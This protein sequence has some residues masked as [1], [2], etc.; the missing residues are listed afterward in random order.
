[1][2]DFGK[3]KGADIDDILEEDPGYLV[4]CYENDVKG[5]VD[6]DMYKY[7]KRKV[8]EIA[9]DVDVCVEY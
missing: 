4:W 6:D 8:I 5:L 2:I 9:C 3:Y 1:M 7:A